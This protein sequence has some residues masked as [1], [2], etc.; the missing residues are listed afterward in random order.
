MEGFS[1]FMR[2]IGD[3]EIANELFESYKV[4]PYVE[5]ITEY[6]KSPLD[7][8]SSLSQQVWTL[9]FSGRAPLCTFFL[10]TLLLSSFVRSWSK[11]FKERSC[12]ISPVWGKIV[13]AS[14]YTLYQQI[15][16]R[17]S[18]S[19]HVSLHIKDLF[20]IV[21]KCDIEVRNLPRSICIWWIRCSKKIHLS[22]LISWNSQKR[23]FGGVL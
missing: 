22:I 23:S 4:T 12:R 10:G 16:F 15:L 19:I 13:W 1:R 9:T 14:L 18:P 5:K 7:D 11:P 6:I 17:S 20:S 8:E 3:E 21:T 2:Q